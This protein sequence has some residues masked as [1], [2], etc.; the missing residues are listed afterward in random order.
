M[1]VA[2][3][4]ASKTLST[5]Q[6]LYKTQPSASGRCFDF[7]PDPSKVNSQFGLKQ[8]FETEAAVERTMLWHA[9]R[10]GVQRHLRK[11]ISISYA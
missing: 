2:E 1:A 4:V 11:F 9:H 8:A 3:I 10:L 5:P 6:V 7:F